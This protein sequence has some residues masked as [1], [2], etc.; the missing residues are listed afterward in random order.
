MTRIQALNK[1]GSMLAYSSFEFSESAVKFSTLK[2]NAQDGMATNRETARALDIEGLYET[3]LAH[4]QFP[5][6]DLQP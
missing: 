2:E 4:W 6:K 1:I 3:K 5:L